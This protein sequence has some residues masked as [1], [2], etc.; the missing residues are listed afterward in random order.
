M[1]GSPNIVFIQE[2]SLKPLSY[3]VEFIDALFPVYKQNKG[4]HQNK[5]YFLSTEDL[6][7][8]SN[9]KSI[10]MGMG[11]TC[12]PFFLFTMEKFERNV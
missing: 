11:D 2:N 10:D 5:P 4:G 9:E 12:Y 3:L 6:L 7:K 8:W 1:G